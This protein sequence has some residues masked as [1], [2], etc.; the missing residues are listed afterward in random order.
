MKMPLFVVGEV[1]VLQSKKS[2]ELNGEHQVIEVVAPGE[3]V[4][5]DGINKKN[6]LP[7]HVYRLGV[8]GPTGT[9][10]W[11]ESALR[12]RHQPG[13]YSFDGLKQILAMPVSR[14]DF[15]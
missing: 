6:N 9:G 13:E 11:Y 15:A 5:I 12:K 4:V 14:G 1:V 8:I 10:F 7:R 2:P 3:T